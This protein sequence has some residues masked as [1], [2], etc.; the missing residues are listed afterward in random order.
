[1]RTQTTPSTGRSRRTA[2][3]RAGWPRTPDTFR[4][5]VKA[6]RGGAMRAL[7]GDDQAESV[8]WLTRTAFDGFGSRLGSVLYRVPG[9]VA[10]TDERHDRLA[11]LLRPS[12]GALPAFDHGVPARDVARRRDLRPV[13]RPWRGPVRDRSGRDGRPPFV[14]VTGPFLY[15]RLRRTTSDAADLDA[16][17][18]G[19][20]RSSMPGWT[21]TPSSATTRPVSPGRAIALA[22]PDRVGR[23][24]RGRLGRGRLG[25]RQRV[26][27]R[28]EDH[29]I[30]SAPRCRGS[31][32]ARR[33]RRRSSSPDRPPSLVA[34][35]DPRPAGH[36]D[37]DLVLGMR[38][39]AVDRAGLEGIQPDAQRRDPEEFEVGP[40]G[41]RAAGLSRSASS[42]AN[43]FVR[44]SAARVGLVFPT[45]AAFGLPFLPACPVGVLFY[46]LRRS[47]RHGR[48]RPGCVRDDRADRRPALSADPTAV[49]TG[50]PVAR[51]HAGPD[52]Q[53][54]TDSPPTH[55]GVRPGQARDPGSS[56]S[57]RRPGLHS[58]V[59]VVD[60]GDGTGRL[61]VV[62]QAGRIK[63]RQ[64]WRRRRPPPFLDIRLQRILSGGERGLLG[65]RIRSRLSP[66]E[67][68]PVRRLHRRERRHRGLLVPPV[69]AATPDQV[70]PA[71]ERVI[72]TIAQPF[73]NHNGGDVVFGPRRRPVH[74]D[75]RRGLR[76]RPDGQRPQTPSGRCWPS[77]SASPARVPRDGSGPPATT[78]NAGLRDRP[79]RQARDPGVGSA[80]PV[81]VPRST[82]RRATCGSAMSARALWEEVDLIR[83]VFVAQ[84]SPRTSAGT[85]MEG[86]H[87]YEQRHVCDPDRAGPCR[88]PSTTTA[89]GCARSSA[90][91][92]DATTRP[93]PNSTA[94]ISVSAHS[95]S[96]NIWA[97]SMPPRTGAQ[98]APGSCSGPARR[99]RRSART[100]R[101]AFISPISA[102]AQ[103]LRLA[104]GD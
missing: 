64:G 11:R 55:R 2:R 22:R 59:D 12:P 6:Q 3:S 100:R 58:P 95:C 24:E 56:R 97:P 83:H 21:P 27:G 37:V 76:R 18:R 92:S 70:D 53:R 91:S 47:P 8:G 48:A 41:G 102:R 31:G 26:F 20:R 43:P 93:S 98:T 16:W 81:A 46:A 89:Q 13:A 73:A 10:R 87:C 29:A 69:S 71:S 7:L 67:S 39:L 38:R 65:A 1:M 101:A 14:R 84:P 75:G 35:R 85:S 103:I 42:N 45:I 63:I 96:G 36:H 79:Q 82:A 62:E 28:R 25:R 104:P 74:R 86:A 72:L 9:E 77:S 5:A 60:A 17:A 44:S 51:P 23:R 33:R 68:T 66:T 30:P 54:L 94:A 80:Q 78:P 90:G 61:F 15:L 4:F 34:H 50:Y 52:E 49:P 99:S 19:S 88:S 32:V 57:P 40:A